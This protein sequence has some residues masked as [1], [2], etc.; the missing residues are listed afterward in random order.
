MYVDI[1][2]RNGDN[3]HWNESVSGDSQFIC[4]KQIK[5]FDSVLWSRKIQNYIIGPVAKYS[6]SS[7]ASRLPAGNIV[8]ALHHKL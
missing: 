5:T 6:H 2:M 4:Q 7:F 1:Y 3:W 8:G